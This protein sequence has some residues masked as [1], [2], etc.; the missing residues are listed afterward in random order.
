[1][2]WLGIFLLLFGFGCF[3]GLVYGL[4]RFGIPTIVWGIGQVATGIREGIREG[5]RDGDERIRKLEAARQAR[6][7]NRQ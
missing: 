2:S 6:Q 3:L 5:L 4:I 7:A 1:M